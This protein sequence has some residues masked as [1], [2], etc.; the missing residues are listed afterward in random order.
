MS[1][2]TLSDLRNQ[3][4]NFDNL[5]K[6]VEKISNPKSNYKQGDDREW[7]PTVD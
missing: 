7:K 1:F 2:N 4:G 6:E 3:R 5:M